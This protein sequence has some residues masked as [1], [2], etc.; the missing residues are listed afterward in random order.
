M[1]KV[2]IWSVLY[3]QRQSQGS[4]RSCAWCK[5]W[6]CCPVGAGLCVWS[7][8]ITGTWGRVSK[9]PCPT[10]L[11]PQTRC[12]SRVSLFPSKR[13]FQERSCLLFFFQLLFLNET[14]SWLF[15]FGWVNPVLLSHERGF[16]WV[17]FWCVCMWPSYCFLLLA[18]PACPSQ[19]TL[20]G[21]SFFFVTK[22]KQSDR[23]ELGTEVKVLQC[24]VQKA[25]KTSASTSCCWEPLGIPDGCVYIASLFPFL[26]PLTQGRQCCN[27]LIS[28][29]IELSIPVSW[30]QAQWKLPTVHLFF[31][32]LAC[33]YEFCFL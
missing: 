2:Q 1:W 30:E 32:F 15:N 4:C 14:R 10:L 6:S 25:M 27:N 13:R 22:E 20:R 23:S 8:L 28:T 21:S 7:S 24:W 29:L 33:L 19:T 26:L 12:T 31:S 9:L 5:A 17:F 11:L 3:S 16:L 18:T